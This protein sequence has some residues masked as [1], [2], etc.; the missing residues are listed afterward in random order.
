MNQGTTISLILNSNTFTHN[1]TWSDTTYSNESGTYYEWGEFN[2]SYVGT[3][4]EY[5]RI[6]IT[7]IHANITS[8]NCSYQFTSDNTS[9]NK[10]GNWQ[11]GAD[12]GFAIILNQS[13]WLNA[14]GCYGS[15]PFPFSSDGSVFMVEKITIPSNIGNTTYSCSNRTWDAGYYV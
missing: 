11:T 7:D 6:N 14:N 2:I 15:N 3:N 13:N 5:I 12:G 1:G 10:G 4:M 8:S 9:W